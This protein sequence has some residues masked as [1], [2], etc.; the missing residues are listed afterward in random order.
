MSA[1]Q[2]MTMRAVVQ[3][4]TATGVDGF[5]HPVKPDFTAHDTFPCWAWSRADRA[6]VDG[7]KAA[8]IEDFRALFPRSA[9]VLAGDRITNITDRLGAVLFPGRFQIETMQFKRD[10]QEADLEAVA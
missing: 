4:N 1:R 7:S 3:R 2:R 6:I 8:L 5:G 9:D 10:H